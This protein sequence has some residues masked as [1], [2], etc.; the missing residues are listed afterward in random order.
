MEYDYLFVKKIDQRALEIEEA[1][2]RTQGLQ[3]LVSMKTDYDV[4]VSLLTRIERR[5]V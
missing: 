2:F 5:W 4:K 3:Y 1:A